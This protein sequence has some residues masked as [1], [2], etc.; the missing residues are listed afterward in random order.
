MECWPVSSAGTASGA[1]RAPWTVGV[2]DDGICEKETVSSLVS[3]VM[4]V[5]DAGEY[6]TPTL[7]SVLS[8]EE[9]DLELVVVDDGSRD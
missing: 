4:S 1:S 5:H 8:Q 7:E 9:V 2:E 3:V 6:L